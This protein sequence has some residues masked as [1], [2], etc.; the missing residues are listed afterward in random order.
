MKVI[1]E[2]DHLTCR[3]L[4]SSGVKLGQ[5]VYTISTSHLVLIGGILVNRNVTIKHISLSLSFKPTLL[6]N[7]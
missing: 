7:E 1:T 3:P 6:T 5:T 2:V 4:G